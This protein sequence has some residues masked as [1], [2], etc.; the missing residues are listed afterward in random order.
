VETCTF[1]ITLAYDGTAYAGWQVQ[2]GQATL[3]GVLETSLEKILGASVRVEGSGRTDAGVHALGQVAS[4]RVETHLTAE[5][6]LRALNGSTPHDVVVRAVEQVESQFHA[7][8]DAR[9]KH[10]RY[11]IHNAAVAD[12]FVRHYSWHVRLPL[13]ERA[14]HEAA[15]A[16]VGR[17]DFAS[18][19]THGSER[20]TT[21]RTVERIEVA[22][23]G[24]PEEHR[25]TF[26]VVADGFLYNM[27]RN[28]TGTLVEVGRGVKPV[29]WPGQVLDALDRRAAGPTAPPQ[30]LFLVCVDYDPAPPS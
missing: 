16:L 19:Q 29:A 25:L 12:P 8:R 27:V 10:Y 14:M 17:H 18:Y 15:Q 6:L 21:V 20:Q 28:I 23:G 7:R 2:P 1:K 11:V 9:R 3:Q 30:G 24:V 22:R 5:V 26:D 13:D 4:F